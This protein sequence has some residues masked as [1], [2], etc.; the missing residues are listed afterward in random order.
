MIQRIGY[1]ILFFSAFLFQVVFA[2]LDAPEVEEVYGGRINWIDAAALNATTTRI[3][4][5]TESAN[6][7]FYTQVNHSVTPAQIDTFRAVPDVDSDDGFGSGILNFA[8]DGASGRVFFTSMGNLYSADIT[9][10]S[11]STIDNGGVFSVTCYQGWLFYLKDEM[12][13][14]NLHFGTI[15]SVSGNFV[16]DGNSPLTV[17]SGMPGGLYTLKVNPANDSLYIFRSGIPPVIYSSSNS[18]HNLTPT[19]SFVSV[20]VSGLGSGIDYRAFGIG[21]DGRLFVGTVHGMEPQ[22]FKFIGYTDNNGATWD[23][24]S[25]TMG[26]TSGPNI[27]CAGSDSSYY[28]YFGSAVSNN[29]GE[30]GTW[31]SIA[32]GSFETHPNDGVVA[33]DPNDPAMI[34]LTTDQGIGAS[35]NHGADIFEIDPGVE[36]VQ[37]NDFN[38]NGAK[39]IAWTASKSGIRRVTDYATPSES[40]EIFFPNG[41]GSPYYSIAM[42]TSD[43]SGNTAYAGNVRV[44]KTLDGGSNWMQ[45]FTVEDTA[46]HFDFWSYISAIKLSPEDP[47]VVVIGVNSPSMGVNGGLFYST[48]GGM[49]WFHLDTSPYNTEVKDIA[50]QEDSNGNSYVYVACEYVDDGTN[51]SYGVKTVIHDTN[52]VVTFVNDM[53]G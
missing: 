11:L 47:N 53:L 37:V 26:G 31:Q 24:L 30:P 25:T 36:A 12:G 34:F 35:E 21:P 5:S 49:F 46:Y 10:G 40:W 28:V 7:L 41:D 33:A 42:D 13:N 32:W 20:D 6:S 9:P 14:L 38:M 3:Y 44:Y 15:D 45:V 50:F 52:D 1:G 2:Q 4:I 43:A 18:F 23:T 16:E 22:H 39:S 8:A 19:T 48:D 27:A 29:K 51:S 17:T